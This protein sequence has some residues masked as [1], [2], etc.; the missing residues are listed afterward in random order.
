MPT[1]YSQEAND[2]RKH[3]VSRWTDLES[4]RAPVFTHMQD[5]SQHLAPR[6]GRYFVQDRDRGG[7]HKYNKILDSTATQAWN[8]ATAG[9]MAGASSPARVWF[10]LTTA[11]PDLSEFHSVRL[12]LDDVVQRMMRVFARS[13]TYAMLQNMYGELLAFGTS[14]NIV[15]A[16]FERVI[17]HYPIPAGEYCL[18]QSNKH[19]IDTL[20]RKFEWTVAQVVDEFGIDAV[21][22]ATRRMYENGTLDG[23]VEILH[24]I[25][26]R[27]TRD[28]S[29]LDSRNMEWRSVYLEYGGDTGKDEG[30]LREGGFK[31]FPVMA[32]RWRVNTGDVYG[33]SPGMDILG[34]IRQL[35][36]QQ[37]RKGQAIDYMTYPPLLVPAGMEHEDVD[38]L[39]GGK[40]PYDGTDAGKAVKSAWDVQLDLS[41]LMQDMAEVK[42]RIARGMFADLFQDLQGAPIGQ[43]REMT[44][45]EI[46]VR[47]EEKLLQL[48]PVVQRVETE[49]LEPLV[50]LTFN[51]MWERGMIPPPPSELEGHELDIE[52][53]GTLS[54]AQKMVGVQ[55]IERFGTFVGA[56]QQMN[57]EAV[58]KFNV[59][60][61]TDEYAERL[62]VPPSLVVPD[63]QVAALRKARNE[64][65][66]AKEQTEAMA[67]QAK[68][69]RDLGQTPAGD[70]NALAEAMA[71]G[72]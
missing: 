25:E 39:P 30:I 16:D 36:Q 21:S 65:M 20:Y 23:R 49:G 46:M 44:A 42:W 3:V 72:V 11:D 9:I 28:S 1:V 63:E 51:R 69:A 7:R 34:D 12:W 4:R 56:L 37:L 29:K 62:G 10:R 55:S 70:G 5:I 53:T 35:Q 8:V 24:A 6:S 32:P 13:N 58:D 61:A 50:D 59:D 14:V 66:A 41:A 2:I 19:E 15:A 45:R 27:R 52:Y 33:N 48:G 31:T 43:G 57:P 17:H 60:E 26:P 68:A 64:A 71:Q 54:Q 38:T 67:T 18:G 47:Y 40:I 22:H